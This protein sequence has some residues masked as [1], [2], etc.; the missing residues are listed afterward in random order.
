M[1]SLTDTL[2]ELASPW[3]TSYNNSN[4][5]STLVTFA[6]LGGLLVAGG[7]A[8]ATDRATLR[9]VPSGAETDRT[10]LSELRGI[11]R[12]VLL[13]L[14]VTFVSGGLLLAADLESLLFAPVFWLKMGLIVILLGNGAF[15]QRTERELWAG[16]ARPERA[17]RRLRGSAW[18]SLAL[19]F[20]S[21][22]LGTALLA[23]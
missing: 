5:L 4:V 22:L 13:G 16:S 1:L 10:H 14:L 18:A 15:L 19:W 6:H 12:P 3:A 20:G 7:F 23:V 9:F 8:L 21:L 2:T 17:W 11:H